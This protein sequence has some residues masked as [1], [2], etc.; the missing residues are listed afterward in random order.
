[1]VRP[2]GRVVIV[3][4]YESYVL[5]P[6]SLFFPTTSK[7][8]SDVKLNHDSYLPHKNK[9]TNKHGQ[10]GGKASRSTSTA[11]SHGMCSVIKPQPRNQALNCRYRY[12][13]VGPQLQAVH[14]PE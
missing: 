1:M 7:V 5:F 10:Y 12:S 3:D 2:F 6:V 13:R 11:H 8:S 4:S 14:A 9:Q